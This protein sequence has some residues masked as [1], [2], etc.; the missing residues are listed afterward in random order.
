MRAH[1]LLNVLVGE[2]LKKNKK[3][4]DVKK[5]NPSNNSYS[6]SFVLNRAFRDKVYD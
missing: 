5:I 3:T 6:A 4:L 2:K 1:A